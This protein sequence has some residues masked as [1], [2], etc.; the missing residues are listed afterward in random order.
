MAEPGALCGGGSSGFP[1]QR[2][3]L[4][5]PLTQHPGEDL[6]ERLCKPH[7]FLSPMHFPVSGQADLTTVVPGHGLEDRD[8]S[9]WLE[10]SAIPSSLLAPQLS[11]SQRLEEAAEIQRCFFFPLLESTAKNKKKIE[12]EPSPQRRVCRCDANQHLGL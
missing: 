5:V 6:A 9:S 10:P 8:I 1:P 11:V 12:T 2:R 4:G 3:Y 7:P